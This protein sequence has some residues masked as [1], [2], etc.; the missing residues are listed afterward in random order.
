MSEFYFTVMSFHPH[1]SPKQIFL[2]NFVPY[3][4]ED[5]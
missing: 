4:K 1:K 3:F 5:K 2:I